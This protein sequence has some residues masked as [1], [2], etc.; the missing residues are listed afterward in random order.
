MKFLDNMRRS[1]E[2]RRD[3]KTG[4]YS[5]LWQAV[6]AFEN[7]LYYK[8]HLVSF[9]PARSIYIDATA[10]CEPGTPRGCAG[11]FRLHSISGNKMRTLPLIIFCIYWSVWV[12]RWQDRL[13]VFQFHSSS[14]CWWFDFTRR[15]DKSFLF[16][17]KTTTSNT[18]PVIVNMYVV[19][20]VVAQTHFQRKGHD[21]SPPIW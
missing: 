8:C 2:R 12:R 1:V 21:S 17:F 15:C 5:R 9:S 19:V 13:S 6:A 4:G 16:T 14:W 20:I 11:V 18:Q 3:G 10:E 7:T